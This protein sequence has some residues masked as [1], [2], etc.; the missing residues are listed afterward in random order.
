M[1]E[2]A[3]VAPAVLAD[4]PRE[5]LRRAFTGPVASGVVA[6]AALAVARV[7]LGA[8][9]LTFSLGAFVLGT[10]VQEFWRGMRSRQAML[11][12]STPRAISRLVGKNRRRYGGYIIHVGI[13]AM[14]VGVAASSV[15]R[16]EVQKTLGPGQTMEAGPYQLRYE[17]ITTHEDG[18]LKSLAAV[19]TVS[20]GGRPLGTL[21]PEKRFYKKPQ[22]PT[23]EVAMRSRLTDDLYLVLGSYDQQTGLVTILAYVNPLVSWIWIGGIILVLG[24]GVGMWPTAAERREHAYAPDAVRVAAE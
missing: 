10:I 21:T 20:E 22:Q 4:D 2:V 5:R 23:T 17:K 9:W 12:E 3:A 19:M 24:T 6:A 1:H 7:P 15:F 11:H 16:V 18:H 13:V 14:F 8:A